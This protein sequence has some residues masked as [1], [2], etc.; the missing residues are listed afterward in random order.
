MKSCNL[1]DAAS[2]GLIDE[3]KLMLESGSIGEEDRVWALK[4]AAKFGH[5]EVCKLLMQT[6]KFNA[7][8][9]LYWAAIGGHE[10]TCN[11][12]IEYGVDNLDNALLGAVSKSKLEICQLLLVHGADLKIL[13]TPKGYPRKIVYKFATKKQIKQARDEWKVRQVMEL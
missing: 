9:I 5:V 1:V 4:I 12:M 3:C 6:A 10:N 7:N 2:N 13:F 8:D 11:L